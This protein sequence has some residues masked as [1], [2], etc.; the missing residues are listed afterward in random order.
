MNKK[1]A[2]IGVIL[3]LLLIILLTNSSIKSFRENDKNP[4]VV[5]E[6]IS[7]N[8]RG[9]YIFGFED[10]PWCQQLYPVLDK[11]LSE[12]NE[13]AYYVDTH[14]ENFTGQDRENLKKY[15]HEKTKFDDTVVPL[16]VMISEDGTYQYHVGT[17]EGHD[18]PKEQLTVSQ[19]NELKNNLKNMILKYKKNK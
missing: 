16:I 7:K 2:M 15:M 8:K 19:E 5:L 14:K 11:V 3:T 10:C 18:A 9:I 6:N 12:Y 4:K 1:Y 17:L 13:K